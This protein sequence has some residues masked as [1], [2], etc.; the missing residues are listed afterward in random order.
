[1][2]IGDG[3]CRERVFPL[4]NTKDAEG[5]YTADSCYTSA[6]VRKDIHRHNVDAHADEVL[7]A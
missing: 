2:S 1:V 4:Q 7:A 3:V 5:P 6:S